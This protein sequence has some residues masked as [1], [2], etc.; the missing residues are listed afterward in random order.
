MLDDI[1]DR[2]RSYEKRLSFLEGQTRGQSTKLIDKKVFNEIDHLKKSLKGMDK[3]VADFEK[4]FGKQFPSIE[5]PE[6]K[7]EAIKSPAN[8]PTGCIKSILILLIIIAFV[9]LYVVS[10]NP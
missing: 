2:I 6:K 4:S 5:K 9:Y 7:P 10:Q 1:N 8:N 3:V